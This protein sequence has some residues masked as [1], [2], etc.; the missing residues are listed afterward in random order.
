MLSTRMIRLDL[1]HNLQPKVL[2]DELD[3]SSTQKFTIT[4]LTF[5]SIKEL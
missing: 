3:E 1:H 4:V 2:L 5:L